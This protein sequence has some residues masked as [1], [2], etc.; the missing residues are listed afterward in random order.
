[1]SEKIRLTAAV[2]DYD[3]HKSLINGQVKP[4]GIK[5]TVLPLPS[6]HRHW[7]MM[8][9]DEFDISEMSMSSYLILKSRHLKDWT[10]IP[11]FP[12]RRFRHSFIFINPNKSIKNPRQLEGKRIGLRTWQATMGVWCRGILQ[13]EYG[14]DLRSI[15]WVTQDPEDVEVDFSPDFRMERAPEHTNID[16]M[17]RKGELDAIIYPDMTHSFLSGDPNIARLFPDFKNEE[18]RYFNNTGIF[19]IMHT[20]VIKESVLKDY[21]WVAKNM[22]MAF[23]QS[24][25][26]AWKEMSD[27][28]RVS[29]AWFRELIEEQNRILGEDPW[30]IGL[31]PNRK[32]L[33]KLIEYSLDQGMMKKRMELEELFYH[34]TLDT[35][36]AELI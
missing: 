17:L 33:E 4:N 13:E 36:P 30:S 8:R 9:H 22:L 32:T 1:M 26:D 18:I 19:P 15:Q 34:S 5:L 28:R 10:A 2:G 31:E 11:V 6:G 20:V 3:I 12:H 7:R 16:E 35:T 14:V 25:N 23:E 27:P 29:A 21:P 24:K